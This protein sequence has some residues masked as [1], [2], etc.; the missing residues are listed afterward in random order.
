MVFRNCMGVFTVFTH[1]FHLPFASIFRVS[2]RRELSL[3]PIVGTVL[4]RSARSI[5]EEP[6]S[7]LVCTGSMACTHCPAGQ[8]MYPVGDTIISHF[9]HFVKHT[10]QLFLPFRN[11]SHRPPLYMAGSWQ[12]R[13]LSHAWNWQ[14]GGIAPLHWQYRGGRER[15]WCFPSPPPPA[16]RG[17]AFGRARPHSTSRAIPLYTRTDLDF[18]FAHPV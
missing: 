11:F 12:V 15:G 9:S 10:T 3:L 14:R 17:G 7:R 4:P 8:G 6:Q 1:S 5:V 2:V 13:L 18:I 16:E